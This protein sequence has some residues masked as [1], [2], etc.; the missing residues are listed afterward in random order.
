MVANYIVSVCVFEKVSLSVLI[1]LL[2]NLLLL[3]V[4]VVV[5]VVHFSPKLGQ[6]PHKQA[7]EERKIRCMPLVSQCWLLSIH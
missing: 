7:E 5:V 1:I 3:V 4:V 6:K 2:L